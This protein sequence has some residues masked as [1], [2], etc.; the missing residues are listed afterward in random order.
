MKHHL[1]SA[2]WI[3]LVG[4]P[5]LLVGAMQVELLPDPDFAAPGAR[6]AVS[7]LTAVAAV[8]LASLLAFGARQVQESSPVVLTWAF[9]GISAAVLARSLTM[10][11]VLVAV[12]APWLEY[13]RH[14]TVLPAA[15]FLAIS[16]FGLPARVQRFIVTS[17]GTL[18]TLS[19]AAA[20]AFGVIAFMSSFTTIAP[21]DLATAAT[22]FPSDSRL[23]WGILTVTFVLLG[24]AMGRYFALYRVNKS[25]QLAGLLIGSAFFA[26][27]EL[28]DVM[29]QQWEAGWW[30]FHVLVLLAL[31]VSLAGVAVQY[32]HG[33]GLRGVVEGFFLRDSIEQLRGGYA[34]VIKVL[35]GAV[36]AKHPYTRGHSSR[37]AR[38]SFDIAQELHL[39]QQRV[40]TIHQAAVLHDIGKIAVPDA[41]LNKPG[42]LTAE[43]FATIREH[44]LRGHEMLRD[45]RSLRD[46]LAGVRFHH[47]RLDGSGYPDGLKGE[48][49][50]LDARIIAVA[51]VFDALTSRRSY[52]DSYDVAHAVRTLEEEAGSRLDAECV[53]ALLRVLA[54]TS[55]SETPPAGNE[56]SSTG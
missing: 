7:L 43:E 29:S 20:S 23:Q 39:G 18:L 53:R 48:Q 24:L 33:G 35:V 12:R 54:R 13:F 19:F 3:A 38:L 25:P 42:A 40:K 36:E 55:T 30:A 16:S 56:A 10:P 46:E 11:G 49:I 26:E 44:P 32:S 2:V 8:A 51:D 37:V 14:A 9:L 45:V 34:D 17:Q 15:L 4:L 52:R 21:L 1:G 31:F 6:F 5:L 50:P 22:P 47:E 27:A 41:I 28:L